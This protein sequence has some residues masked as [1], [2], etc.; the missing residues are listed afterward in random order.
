MSLAF[1]IMQGMN[2]WVAVPLG[3]LGGIAIGAI[4]GVAI[5]YLR[6]PDIVTTIAVG[7]FAGG[8]AY[9][10]SNGRD[11]FRNFFGSGI[12]TLNN[13][14]FLNISYATYLL[15]AVYAVAY[16]LLHKTRW[17]RCLYAT[18]ENPITAKYL[19]H[20]RE[21]LRDSGVCDLGGAD[22]LR[23]DGANL[24]GRQGRGRGRPRLHAR[25]L[26]RGSARRRDLSGG[27]A[28]CRPAPGCS[29]SLSS[30]TG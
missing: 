21:A 23:G 1:L 9:L 2:P 11:I 17:G 26:C 10:F 4:S 3:V 24:G 30:T 29:S 5:A 14:T 16:V 25:H 19:R 7:A 8:A 15:I 28:S 27:R 12:L 18:G 6:L 22:D 20:Q 13:G